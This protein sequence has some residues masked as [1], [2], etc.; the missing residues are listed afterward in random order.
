MRRWRRLDDGRKP[1]YAELELQREF[2]NEPGQ[3]AVFAVEQKMA[4]RQK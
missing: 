4:P 1:G 3:A 2:L